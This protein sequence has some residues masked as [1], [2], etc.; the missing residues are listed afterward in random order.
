MI[1][2]DFKFGFQIIKWFVASLTW[3]SGG[4][5]CGWVGLF[6]FWWGFDENMSLI[7]IVVWKKLSN[8][9]YE[10]FFAMSKR[11]TVSIPLAPGYDLCLNNEKKTNIVCETIIQL[12]QEITNY[13]N[14]LSSLFIVSKNWQYWKFKT[15]VCISHVFAY[16]IGIQFSNIDLQNEENSNIILSPSK[17]EAT[18][19][20]PIPL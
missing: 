13:I 9:I 6:G 8:M 7:E 16:I 2:I 3:V 1:S 20:L 14:I 11:S 17:D 18:R 10:N 15:F 5:S 12:N 4:G 19:L